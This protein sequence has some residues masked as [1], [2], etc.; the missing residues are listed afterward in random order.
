MNN[1]CVA[2]TYVTLKND[3][4][5]KVVL[6][7]AEGIEKHSKRVSQ[8]VTRVAPSQIDKGHFLIGRF[9]SKQSFGFSIKERVCL[10]LE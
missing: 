3:R 1:M 5:C 2:T 6:G 9:Y 7:I 10:D 8:F 4:Q